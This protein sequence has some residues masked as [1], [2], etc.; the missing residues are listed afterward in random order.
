V[1]TSGGATCYDEDVGRYLVERRFRDPFRVLFFERHEPRSRR[2]DGRSYDDGK[3]S[4]VLGGTVTA[5]NSTILT[6]ARSTQRRLGA[7]CSGI[8]GDQ[9]FFD[10]LKDYR[11]RFAFETPRPGTCRSSRT[12]IV[13]VNILSAVDLRLGPFYSVHPHHTVGR[14]LRRDG[15]DKAKQTQAI[16]GRCNRSHMPLTTAHF[17]RHHSN[18]IGQERRAGKHFVCGPEAPD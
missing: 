16:P 1:G 15:V 14:G 17:E 2:V 10:A 9:A 7:L 6:T 8:L 12:I 5:E 11:Q 18:S 13:D 4:G 3:V